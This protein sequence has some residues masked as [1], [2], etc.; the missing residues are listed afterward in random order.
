MNVEYEDNGEKKKFD[1]RKIID[2]KDSEE[3]VTLMVS[4]IDK[5]QTQIKLI[6]KA[7]MAN[8]ET[9]EYEQTLSINSRV[10]DILTP[11]ETVSK[12]KYM[13]YYKGKGL[14]KD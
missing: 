3:A 9:N 10:E 12:Q 6:I 2:G 8:S 11:I 1:C 13:I 7:V 4:E 5:L 14:K